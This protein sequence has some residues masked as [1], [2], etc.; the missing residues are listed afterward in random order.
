M[1]RV[2]PSALSDVILAGGSGT[3]LALASRSTNI[4]DNLGDF[5]VHFL[6]RNHPWASSALVSLQ[7]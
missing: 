4:T 5:E 1:S 6:S 3:T 2:T 7:T